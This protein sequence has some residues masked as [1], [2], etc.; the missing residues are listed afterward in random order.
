MGLKNLQNL[1]ILTIAD[2]YLTEIPNIQNL[3]NIQ[4]LKLPDNRIKNV[5]WDM[6]FK[7]G[8]DI[9]TPENPNHDAFEFPDLTLI[10]LQSNPIE[11][12][13]EDK[14]KIEVLETSLN[15]YYD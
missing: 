4:M 14:S 8:V 11:I 10:N 12:S 5:D 15:V 2:A 3:K 9:G 1:E 13:S 7:R 6:F